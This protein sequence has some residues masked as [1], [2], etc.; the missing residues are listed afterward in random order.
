M[1]TNEAKKWGGKRRLTVFWT[2]V[3]A[4]S[5]VSVSRSPAEGALSPASWGALTC[6]QGSLF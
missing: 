4:N 5:A 2:A 3:P 6:K 1:G